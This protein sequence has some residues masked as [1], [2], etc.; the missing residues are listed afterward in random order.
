MYVKLPKVKFPN[1]FTEILLLFA[2]RLALLTVKKS[3][4]VA[5][6]VIFSLKQFRKS[7]I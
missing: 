3:E 7:N 2:R 5:F 4:F 1:T 6:V